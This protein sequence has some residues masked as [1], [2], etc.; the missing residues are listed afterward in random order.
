MRPHLWTPAS[1]LVVATA[2]LAAWF[3]PGNRPH[4]ERPGPSEN[5]SL[6]AAREGPD[7]PDPPVRTERE[8]LHAPS[9]RERLDGVLG[10]TLSGTEP[11]V[12]IATGTIHGFVRDAETGSAVPR[13][14]LFESERDR[15]E[16]LPSGPGRDERLRWFTS[17]NGSFRRAGLSPGSYVLLFVAEGYVSKVLEG[18]GTDG[19]PIEV[20]LTREGTIR[21][22]VV[23]RGTAAPIGGA[24]VTAVDPESRRWPRVDVDS[25]DAGATTTADGRFELRGLGPGSVAV[26]ARHPRFLETQSDPID[27]RP[28]LDAEGIVVSMLRG[29]AVE[30]LVV[31]RDRAPLDGVEVAALPAL[32]P[33][34]D[35]RV[36]KSDSEGRFRIEGLRPG[37]YRIYADTDQA[38]GRFPTADVLIEEGRTARVELVSPPQG[39]CTVRGRVLRRG[40]P[41]DRAA[42]HLERT[43]ES[44]PW[45]RF[46]VMAC[47]E[48]ETDASGEF[49][50]ENV[51][52][53]SATLSVGSCAWST[54]PLVVPAASEVRFAV[55]L[56]SGEIA[57]RVLRE[58]GG[59]TVPGAEIVVFRREEAGWACVGSAPTLGDGSYRLQG[60]ESGEYLLFAKTDEDPQKVTS[61]LGPGYRR[62]VAV[63][64]GEVACVDLALRPLGSIMVRVFGPDGLPV[65]RAEVHLATADHPPP[66]FF[67]TRVPETPEPGVYRAD[68]I[69]EGRYSIVVCAEGLAAKA[70]EEESIGAAEDAVHRVDLLP[71]T[72]VSVKAFEPDGAVSFFPSVEFADEWGRRFWG[73]TSPRG[74]SVAITLA[75]GAY[76]LTVGGEF[77]E[78]TLPV[79]VGTSKQRIVVPLGEGGRPW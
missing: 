7:V 9:G 12:A 61:D 23:E 8:D 42:I 27:L 33:Q 70:S 65:P 36:G 48:S 57:G 51:P 41:I 19:D 53:G 31:R 28:R 37:L 46:P 52:P 68:R 17:S 66:G 44:D 21:G 34:R 71:G 38:L 25:F 3:I 64:E 67:V 24:T 18:V 5:A 75:P 72:L 22:V 79:T 45:A 47:W 49:L 59:S 55:A 60:L 35:S 4:S 11:A 13:F 20:L 63:T 16:R 77:L 1:A 30:G 14:G 78:R 29:G 26:L 73:E 40:H 15:P 50:L 32:A 10:V 6:H 69:P 54:F 76:R 2:A 56:P 74:T 62:T 58:P 39:G 43:E